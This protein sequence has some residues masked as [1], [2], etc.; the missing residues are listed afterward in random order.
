[1]TQIGIGAGGSNVLRSLGFVEHV[2]TTGQ[3]LNDG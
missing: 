3:Y 1:M 2:F